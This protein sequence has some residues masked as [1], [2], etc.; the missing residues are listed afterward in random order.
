M[1]LKGSTPVLKA[2]LLNP[3]TSEYLTRK[4]GESAVDPIWNEIIDEALDVDP[5]APE[6]RKHLKNMLKAGLPLLQMEMQKHAEKA[7]GVAI[8]NDDIDCV[9]TPDDAD[10]FDFWKLQRGTIASFHVIASFY[11]AIPA[12][13]APSERAFSATTG[14]VTKKRSSI[15]DKLLEDLTVCRDWTS[16]STFSFEDTVVALRDELSSGGNDEGDAIIISKKKN[17]ARGL[18]FTSPNLK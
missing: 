7:L 6:E 17:P 18:T 3:C 4:L 1:Y 16:R 14:V 9:D 13:S 12:T 15:G 10:F 11:L 2:A 5:I 8:E